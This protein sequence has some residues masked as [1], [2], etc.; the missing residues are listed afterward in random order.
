MSDERPLE[1]DRATM[2]HWLEVFA[3]LALD[4][5]DSYATAPASG[6]SGAAANEIAAAA[7]PP[8]PE[9]PL[10]GGPEAA[11]RILSTVLPAS[12]LTSGPGYLAYVP[13]GG[14]YATALANFVAATFNRF[15]GLS[16]AASGPCRLEADV[17]AWLANEFGYGPDARGLLTTGGSLANFSAV[18]TARN[19]HFGDSG[20]LSKAIAYASSQAHHSV[21]KSL[22]LAGVPRRNVREVRVDAHWRMDPDDLR[23]QVV[24]DRAQGL[25]PFLVVESAGTTNTGAIDP[26]EALADACADLGLWLHADGAYGG[27]FVM[28][29][30]G[31]GA[32]AGIQR[33]DSITFD[34]H[35]GM[36]LPYGTGCLLVKDGEKLRRAHTSDADYL[37]DFDRVDRSGEPPSPTEYGPELSRDYRGLRIWLPLMLHGAEAFR[38]ALAE[39]IQITRAFH[40]GLEQLVAAGRP[41]EIVAGPQLST[42]AFRLTRRESESLDGYDERNASLLAGINRRDHVYLSSTTLPVHDGAAFTLRVCVVSFRT[43]Q[44]H[45]DAC[46]ADLDATLAELNGPGV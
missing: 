16:T 10:V 28:C 21:Q 4:E 14:L 32:L 37:Q 15:T 12:L 34:P 43:H 30:E 45:L 20:D 40:A 46:L 26:L 35:K 18:V 29:D 2:E 27:A 17:L 38:D 31:R 44:E 11:A 13:G 23:E 25:R 5:I 8:I 7:S 9:Q 3:K 41:I 24:A 1:P 22:H 19:E 39:K 36:F 6:R 42:V 33:A